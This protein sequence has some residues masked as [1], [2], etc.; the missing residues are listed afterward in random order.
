MTAKS[1]CGS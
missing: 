1:S